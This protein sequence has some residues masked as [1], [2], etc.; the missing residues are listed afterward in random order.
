MKIPFY[1]TNGNSP[2]VNIRDAILIGQAP[3]KGLYLPKSIPTLTDS[4]LNSF[5]NMDYPEMAYKIT[6]KL[7]NEFVPDEV[8]LALCR[9][10][11]NFNLPIENIDNNKYIMRLDRG[12]T[13]A[14]KDFAA[15]LMARLMKYFLKQDGKKLLIL[16]AT[17]GD[18][19]G[20]VADAFFGLE[21]IQVVIL[22]P[23]KEISDRQRKQ[24]TTLGH[25]ITAIG[26]KG[27]FDDCQ[28][29]VKLAFA[30]PDLKKLN[31]SSANSIN[32]ARLLPQ[33]IYYFYAYSRTTKDNSERV[34]FSVPSGN[35]GDLVG[36][37]IA[38]KMGLPVYKFIAAVNENNEFPRFLKTGIYEK[39][40]PSK[41]CLSTAM[42]VGHPSNLS[43][44]V[45]FY[46]GHL[47]EAGI[48]HKKPD[49]EKLRKDIT[50]VSINDEKTKE[51]IINT[52]NDYKVILEPHGAVG[53]AGMLWYLN[54]Q[55]KSDIENKNLATG[56]E[57]YNIN[58]NEV[59]CISLETAD[60]S[61]FP[62]TIRELLG[63]NPE[64]PKSLA[65]V[66]NKTELSL[67]LINADYDI[68]D[69]F[70]KELLHKYT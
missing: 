22:Y 64:M 40:S 37:I 43:R 16:T 21:N 20:A 62:E 68:Y 42:N 69:T 59:A 29:L 51:T 2:L 58:K 56:T 53:W 70:K 47:D 60:P 12:P 3:D 38:F 65:D 36:G 55:F 32:F 10:S 66:Q 4:E 45:D 26:I 67:K 35:F 6:S 46:D 54:N 1:S 33:A 13:S 28:K 15:R 8:L 5:R 7:L 14:F 11:Y 17:S 24:M 25:N 9:E 18:T 30:D 63:I 31:L 39:V 49:M 61:K 19:G 23:E 27:K 48:L 34:I 44:V 52:Y 50:S 57:K 41:N